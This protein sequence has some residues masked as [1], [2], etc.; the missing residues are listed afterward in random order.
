MM[1]SLIRAV[2]RFRDAALVAD[3]EDDFGNALLNLYRELERTEDLV[4]PRIDGVSSL[5][6]FRVR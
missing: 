1:R 6:G 4:E 2:Y 5:L 3:K